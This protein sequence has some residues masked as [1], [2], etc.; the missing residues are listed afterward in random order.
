LGIR[1][2]FALFVEVF[3][4]ESSVYK[5][6]RFTPQSTWYYPKSFNLGTFRDIEK[7]IDHTCV[8]FPLGESRVGGPIIDCPEFFEFPENRYFVA[9]LNLSQFSPFDPFDL[10]P[11]T[12]FLYFFVGSY[13]ER[14]RVLFADVE[15]NQLKRV[16]REHDQWFF[17]GC[18]VN[19]IFNEEEDFSS[20]FCEETEDLSDEDEGGLQWAYHA[21]SEKSKIYGIYTHCQKDEEEIRRITDSDIL[22]LQIGKDFTS[23]G[24]LSVRIAAEDLKNREFQ[25]C[26]FEWGQS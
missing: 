10:L 17:D 24:V 19:E 16:I 25:H 5:T 6:I 11:K 15:T 20:R 7:Y 18:L 23:E 4:L 21:S 26:K 1:Y 2:K 12:G 8:H 3:L 14:G 9:Q 13:G 22:L